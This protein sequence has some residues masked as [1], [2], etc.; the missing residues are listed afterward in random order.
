MGV[1]SGNLLLAGQVIG[2]KT[3]LNEF[4]AYA[5]L[6][7]LKA[8]GA[9][10][11]PRAII[12]LTYALCGFSNISSIGIQIGGIGALAPN[13]RPTLAALGVK[14]LIGGSIACFLTAC[15]AAMLT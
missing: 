14:A 3:I 2:E 13:Q 9:I 12:I 15:V 6:G 1:D 11:D 4:Y 7:R 8:S 10:A 5:T